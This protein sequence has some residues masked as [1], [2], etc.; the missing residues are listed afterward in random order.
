MVKSYYLA[1]GFMADDKIAPTKPF[2]KRPDLVDIPAILEYD[3]IDAKNDNLG[4]DRIYFYRNSMG[5]CIFLAEYGP[6]SSDENM[7]NDYRCERTIYNRLYASIVKQI[8]N[9]FSK[10]LEDVDWVMPI[11]VGADEDT[12]GTTSI[13][14][15]SID[16]LIEKSSLYDSQSVLALDAMFIYQS[17]TYIGSFFKSLPIKTQLTKY[18]QYQI[19]FYVQGLKIL[20]HPSFFLTNVQ[21]ITLMKQ[22]YLQWELETQIKT[23]LEISANSIQLFEFLSR[24]TKDIKNQIAS[25]LMSFLSLILLYEPISDLISFLFPHFESSLISIVLRFFVGICSLVV[26]FKIAHLMIGTVKEQHEYKWK[27]KR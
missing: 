6:F 23:T 10:Q 1:G 22:Y 5:V 25:L 13:S 16:Y 14:L 19:S 2:F 20:E 26:L 7:W 24:N 15:K 11:L 8:D 17:I 27:S 21:E 12:V 9:R 18:E 3:K 4:N